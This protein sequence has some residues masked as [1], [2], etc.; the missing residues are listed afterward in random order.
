[1][2]EKTKGAETICR[3]VTRPK[4]ELAKYRVFPSQWDTR[5]AYHNDRPEVESMYQAEVQ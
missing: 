2:A 4:E 3:Y 1:M 5:F